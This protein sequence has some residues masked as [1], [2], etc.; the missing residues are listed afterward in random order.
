MHVRLLNE[1]RVAHNIEPCH[2]DASYHKSVEI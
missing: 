2:L 1:R